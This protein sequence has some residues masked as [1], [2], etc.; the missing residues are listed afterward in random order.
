MIGHPYQ[1]SPGVLTRSNSK[2]LFLCLRQRAVDRDNAD[3]DAADR[4]IY[5]CRRGCV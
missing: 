4:E 3:R 1:N 5:S 2:G